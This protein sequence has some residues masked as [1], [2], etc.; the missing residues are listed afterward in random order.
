MI[1][2]IF[3]TRRALMT[4]QRG[5]RYM[6]TACSLQAGGHVI[7]DQR[8]PYSKTVGKILDNKSNF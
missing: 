5:P 4:L 2:R 6:M 7:A 8:G 3:P 1:L